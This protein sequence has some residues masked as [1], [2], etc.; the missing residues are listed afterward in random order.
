MLIHP[1]LGNVEK[2]ANPPIPTAGI[3]GGQQKRTDILHVQR[4]HLIADWNNSGNVALVKP[5]G[6][7]YR[8]L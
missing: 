1:S 2:L 5:F 8:A 3:L 4:D 7:P 6:V